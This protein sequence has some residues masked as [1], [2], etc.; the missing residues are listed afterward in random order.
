MQ[1]VRCRGRDVG[2]AP[3][4]RQ[5]LLG[6][7]R[8]IIAVD[9][10]IDD[11]GM[12]GMPGEE[13]LEDRRAGQ[14]S[15]RSQAGSRPDRAP[16]RSASHP[17]GTATPAPRRHRP[18]SAAAPGAAVRRSPRNRRQSPRYSPARAPF[19]R[20]WRGLAR[21][22]A[23]PAAFLGEAP[24][25]NGLPIGT[26][27]MPQVAMAQPGS[28]CR[29]SRNALSA[30]SHQKECSRATARCSWGWTASAQELAKDTVPSFSPGAAMA[31]AAAQTE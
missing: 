8:I 7:R 6:E 2:I 25:P 24:A 9:E 27:A 26:V 23:V 18:A 5:P 20:R 10:V 1:R 29:T 11:A 4:R 22:R 21:S 16:R 13:R 3:R 19:R 17:R 31:V 12:V 28:R 15:C 30:S 14:S